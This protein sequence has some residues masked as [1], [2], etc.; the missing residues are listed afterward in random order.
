M[1]QFNQRPQLGA[2]L[3]QGDKYG[4]R[5][6]SIHCAQQKSLI[7]VITGV[8][9]YAFCRTGFY[10]FYCRRLEKASVFQLEQ[11]GF[12]KAGAHKECPLT[13]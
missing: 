3:S 11:S 8:N 10:I 12:A 6:Q 4:K 13:G 7:V 2:G 1:T 5:I 9:V